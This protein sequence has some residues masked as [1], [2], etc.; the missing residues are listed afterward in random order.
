MTPNPI[1]KVLSTLKKY[2]V[3]CL[4]IG[5]QACIIYGAAEFSRDSDFVILA[6]YENLEHLQKALKHLQATSIYFPPLKIEYLERGHACHFRCA[7]KGVE[8]LRVDLI[9]KLRGC[10]GFEKLWARRKTIRVKNNGG[11]DI[12]SLRDLVQSKKTQ[13]DKDWLMLKRLVENDIA[14]NRV[15]PTDEQV[16]WWLREC[17]SA[18]LL[19][20]ITGKYPKETKET[21]TNRPLLS[22]AIVQNMEQLKLE[23]QK[24]EMAER[25]KDIEYWEPL[26]KE[27]EFLRHEKQKA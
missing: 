12:I 8:G 16:R 21:V 22:L 3:K 10:E 23:L 19:I 20:E 13:R 7:A 18:E 2:Q 5:G 25:S 4:L 1:L 26:K 24:E 6:T 15:K 27:L 14:L 17:R 11:I 9:A